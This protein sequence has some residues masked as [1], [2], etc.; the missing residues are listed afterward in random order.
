VTNRA[1]ETRLSGTKI[2]TLTKARDKQSYIVIIPILLLA[3]AFIHGRGVWQS[4]N[5]LAA[6][7]SGILERHGCGAAHGFVTDRMVGTVSVYQFLSTR[8][9]VTYG[10]NALV[11]T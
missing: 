2:A 4:D 1:V 11:L 9:G 10:G 7:E 8:T 3:T 5:N 6:L